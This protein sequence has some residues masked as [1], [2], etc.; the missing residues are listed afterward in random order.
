ME[1]SAILIM[2]LSMH[3]TDATTFIAA[4]LQLSSLKSEF[5]A[6]IICPGYTALYG[7]IADEDNLLFVPGAVKGYARS[8]RVLR[9]WH[10]KSKNDAKYNWWPE[11]VVQKKHRPVT[12]S[13]PVPTK[14]RLHAKCATVADPL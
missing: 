6:M 10:E 4:F 7:T 8:K 14:L 1:W 9:Q 12:V 3:M 5:G 11:V 13:Q 2:E